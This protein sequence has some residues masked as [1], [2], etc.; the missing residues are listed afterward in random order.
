MH[1]I[2]TVIDLRIKDDIL[3][4]KGSIIRCS[5]CKLLYILSA[6]KR[7][8]TRLYKLFKKKSNCC[9]YCGHVRWKAKERKRK[10]G[11]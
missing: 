7:D 9:P 11:C 4:F 1:S 8:K 3:R 5:K 2:D 6:I 10:I